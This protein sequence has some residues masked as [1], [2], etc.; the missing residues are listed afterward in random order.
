MLDGEHVAP[1]ELWRRFHRETIDVAL[2]TE[3]CCGEGMRRQRF[4]VRQLDANPVCA[5]HIAY[6]V[7]SM[8]RRL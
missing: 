1:M 2:L 4:V 5:G 7:L 8:K 3:L 6:D